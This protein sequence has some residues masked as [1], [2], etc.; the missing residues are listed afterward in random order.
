LKSLSKQASSEIEVQ[1]NVADFYVNKRYKGLGLKYHISVIKE[2]M[3]DAY[4]R[5][6]DVGCGTG[7]L[8]DL[9][10]HLDIVG[11]DISHGMLK[12]HK[13]SHV[14]G[15]ADNMP[16]KDDYFDTV[17]C[18]SVLHHL[19]DARAGLEEIRRVLKPGGTFVCWETNKSWLA[20]LVRSKTQH[21]DHFSSYHSSFR[22]LSGLVSDVLGGVGLHTDFGGYL[23][24]PLLG[25]PDIIDF[26]K[27][28]GGISGALLRL[29]GIISKIPLLNRL[30]F[31]VM[32]RAKNNK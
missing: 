28:V 14:H 13:G 9:Y 15:S 11:I 19:P 5:I 25:F 7:I 4:G 24:Y 20:E 2:L 31:Y 21:G 6:C 16:F 27:F 8:H 32:V 29:D 17:V 1:D 12:H 22:N 3:R 26:S 30:G 18:R 23:A 10:P